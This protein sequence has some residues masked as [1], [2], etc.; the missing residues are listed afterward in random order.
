M[1]LPKL[2]TIVCYGAEVKNFEAF[3]ASRKLAGMDI[4]VESGPRNR[5]PTV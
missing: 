2:R 4:K 1:L 3:V 5:L